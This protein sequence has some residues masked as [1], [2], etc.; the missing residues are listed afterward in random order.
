M[1]STL[2][3]E[4]KLPHKQTW[5]DEEACK[6]HK[7]V[8][9]TGTLANIGRV[10][11]ENPAG[12]R[13]SEKSFSRTLCDTREGR[14]IFCVGSFRLRP[15]IMSMRIRIFGHHN[16]SLSS[17][18]CWVSVYHRVLG[19]GLFYAQFLDKDTF[20]DTLS[21][22]TDIINPAPLQSSAPRHKKRASIKR[23]LITESNLMYSIALSPYF[24]S[25]S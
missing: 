2:L 12:N 20:C 25:Y 10:S 23:L 3:L 22:F 19:S 16:N 21:L 14:P 7:D 18:L 6:I 8:E 17:S 13:F 9:N 15:S 5:R 11:L 1:S 4:T 24:S